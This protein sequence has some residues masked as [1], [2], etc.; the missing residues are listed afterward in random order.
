MLHEH[1][2]RY[3]F[4]IQPFWEMG[5]V[6]NSVRT[7]SISVSEFQ[8]DR[9]VMSC[10]PG[11]GQLGIML[12]GPEDFSGYCFGVADRRDDIPLHGMKQ[13]YFIRFAPGKF[14]ALFDIPS[15]EI[16]AQGV[17]LSLVLPRERL[18]Q[19]KDAVSGRSPEEALLHLFEFWDIDNRRFQ[20]EQNL[21]SEAVQLIWSN[22]GALR[23]KDLEQ[24]TLY[25]A[26]RLQEVVTRQVGSDPSSC[27]GK[28]GF[29]MRLNCL[30]RPER[31][32]IPRRR[33]P[34]SWGTVI[35]P[36][37]LGSSRSFPG[38]APASFKSKF[39]TQC[40]LGRPSFFTLLGEKACPFL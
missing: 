7:D 24:E 2:I 29:K 12:S 17:D 13:G 33:P 22:R 38:S 34:R 11:N 18:D 26:R 4:S 25:S 35:S 9:D 27:A 23:I 37:I 31:G 14:S 36:T 30:P 28:P 15:V 21:A 6:E 19:L 40:F 10:V 32:S 16:P 5:G 3:F 1:A 20:K 39:K 8:W